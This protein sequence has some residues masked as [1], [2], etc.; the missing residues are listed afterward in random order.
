[1]SRLGKNT[2]GHK[3][4][5]VGRSDV[6]VGLDR[7]PG[8]PAVRPAGLIVGGLIM[9]VGM[10]WAYWHTFAQMLHQWRHQPDYSHGYLVLPIAI[11]FLWR[12]RSSLPWGSLRP[13]LWGGALLLLAGAIRGVA[14]AYYLQPLDGWTIPVWVA[15]SVCLLYGRACLWWSLPAIVFLWFMVPIP[16]SAERWLSVPLQGVA[17]RLSTATLVSLGQPAIA[18]GHTILL[19]EQSLFVEDACSGL[20]ILVGIFALAF[21]FALFSRWNWWQKVVVMAAALPIAILA[22]V[23]RIVATGLLYQWV[24]GEAAQTFSHDMSGFVMIFLAAILFWS[25]LI[26]LSKLFHEVEDLS[27]LPTSQVSP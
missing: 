16:Y 2:D 25:L 9:L 1:M 8:G 20:R 7:G 18:E 5:R 10:F 4:T 11:F 21:A 27:R 14:G 6:T 24:S 17:T 15:G 23:C 3:L 12:R 26:Y 19:A 13:D 22:N